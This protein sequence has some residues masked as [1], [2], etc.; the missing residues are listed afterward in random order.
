MA[1]CRYRK[2]RQNLIT[3]TDAAPK[4]AEAGAAVA[5]SRP[6]HAK[7]GVQQRLA[8]DSAQLGPLLHGYGNSAVEILRCFGRETK[9]RSGSGGGGAGG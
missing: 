5:L 4:R 7:I 1:S 6:A 3:H 8:E 2:S 9:H